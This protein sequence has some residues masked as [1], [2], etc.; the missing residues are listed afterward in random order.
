MRRWILALIIGLPLTIMGGNRTYDSQ[1]KTLQ[2]VVNNKWTSRL[3]VMQLGTD[4][5]L[6][7]GFD[8]LSH[9]Y[10]RYVY[11]IERCEADW[12]PS[13][14]VFESDWMEG[15]N[16]LPIDDYA[17]SLNTVVSYTHY[18]L[19]IPNDQVR[20]K[21]SGNYRIHIT[22]EDTDKE[23]AMVEL[24]VTEQTMSL[25]L[26][27]TTNTDIDTNLSHQQLSMSLNYGQW[28]VTAPE[29]QIRTVVMQNGRQ[30]NW[31]RNV[32]PTVMIPNGLEWRHQ[33]DLIFDGGNEYRKYEVLDPSHPTM[34]IDF[35]FFV[36]NE[37]HVF[38]FVDEPR[39]NY[40]YDEDANG[41]FYIRNSD[42][43]ENDITCD[44]VYV[45]YSFLIPERM[46]GDVI[47]DGA[48]TTEAPKNY[49]MGYDEGAPGY[50]A[51]LLQKQGY[52]SYQYLWKPT[53]GK[54]SFMPSEGNYYQTENTY[55]VLVYYKGTGDR[56]WRLTAYRDI[57]LASSDTGDRKQQ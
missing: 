33:K 34:G 15:F 40:I 8:E 3:A 50:Y 47:I 52:Y 54:R 37:Y 7:I 49:V 53:I 20:L 25:A 10:H 38:P 46:G 5:V 28:R 41:A 48:W 4:D 55:Q 11:K 2:A 14:E 44:Y 9:D 12:Q 21:M 32:K 27:A 1:I 57:Q 56:T 17:R 36:G 43:R 6:N 42:N 51:I 45:H 30:D 22:D 31:R 23:V 16:G 35:L 19:Q 13:K 18:R 29:D 26:E 39:P 24:M